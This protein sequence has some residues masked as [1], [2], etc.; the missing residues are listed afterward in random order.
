M[1]LQLSEQWKTLL[2]GTYVRYPLGDAGEEFRGLVAQQYTLQ[3]NWALRC[4]F[5]YRR[6][7]SETLVLLHTYF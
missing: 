3:K 6:H 1:I 4:E 7:D 5:R 2:L